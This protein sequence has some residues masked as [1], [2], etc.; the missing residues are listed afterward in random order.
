[1]FRFSRDLIL[2]RSPSTRWNHTCPKIKITVRIRSHIPISCHTVSHLALRLFGRKLILEEGGKRLQLLFLIEINIQ[3]LILQPFI[4]VDA[5][6]LLPVRI[7]DEGV[8]GVLV[9]LRL[10]DLIPAVIGGVS[11][12]GEV[13]EGGHH[14]DGSGGCIP[15]QD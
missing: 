15:A 5:D 9:P 12:A 6:I 2:E 11:I 14:N 3:A 1:M 13:R 8:G 7:D 4:G 10:E